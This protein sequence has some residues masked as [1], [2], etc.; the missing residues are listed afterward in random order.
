[1]KTRQKTPFYIF[2]AGALL[3]SSLIQLAIPSYAK[4]MVPLAAE[5][6]A[7]A[8]ATTVLAARTT[9]IAAKPAQ[10]AAATSVA[11]SATA[12]IDLVDPMI[13]TGGHGHTYPGASLPFGLVQLSP[14]TRVTTWDGCS[15]YH[16]SD[17]SIMGFSHTHL[18]GTGCGDLGDIL[19]LPTTE[20][21]HIANADDAKKYHAAFEHSDE[22]ASPG[23]YSVMLKP[24]GIKAE[25]TATKRVGFHRYTFPKTKTATIVVDLVHGIQDEPIEETI[26]IV[27][28]N[29]V[30][31]MRRSKGWAKDEYVYFAAKFSKPF[32]AYDP[33]Q[34]ENGAPAPLTEKQGKAVRAALRFDTTDGAPL[35]AKVGL[36]YADVDGALK[37]LETEAKDLDFDQAHKQAREAWQSE[38][39]K[40]DLKCAN[41]ELAKTFY[42]ALYHSLLA[43]V[44]I[45]DV[46]GRYRGSDIAV[47]TAKDFENYSTFSLWDT[48]RAE[49]PLFTIIEPARVTDMLKSF[50]VQAQ[51]QEKKLLPIWP[52]DSNE[53]FCMIG[54]HSFPVIAEAYLKG[55]RGYDVNKLYQLM[56]ENSKAN[57]WWYEKGYLPADK[58]ME[59]VSKTLEFAYDD[60]CLAQL[61]KALGHSDDEK[62][63]SQR[64]QV[65]KNLFDKQ[66]NIMRGKL[67]DGSWRTPFDPI[68]VRRPDQPW[69][70]TE[71]NAWQY[72]F[73]VLQDIPGMIELYGGREKFVAKLDEMFTTKLPDAVGLTDITG[74]I[75]QYAQ[76][77]EP[78]HHIAYLYTCAGAPNKAAERIK[79]IR[80]RYYT[81]APDGLCGNEDCGQMSAWYVFSALGFYPVN[82]VSAQYIFGTPAFEEATITLP[83]GKKFSVLAH[84]VSSEKFYI[85]KALL[86]GKVLDRNYVTHDEIMNGGT[87]E[88]VMAARLTPVRNGI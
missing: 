72:A 51:Y 35:V 26:K 44:I 32:F 87:L 5:D 2:G 1:M 60:Y 57:D 67:A 59:S 39:Q 17:H 83:N 37:N 18:S 36:S 74:V 69:D 43:P 33:A 82:P 63:Y 41:K 22:S 7:V 71:G 78:S 42:T 24:S 21:V 31:G 30:T 58:E 20:N 19:F 6:K 34:A 40:L 3:L 85:E 25:L 70:F 29:T 9:Q 56:V 27:D 76:G 38:L 65:Y 48:F 46:D 15:G 45:S 86:N 8:S 23:Y 84:G 12:Q 11:G 80:D 49:N 66:T 54:Y 64:G 13:G 53:T 10:M 62:K 16:Y 68:W 50:E 79:E 4:E 47:H 28:A 88:F 81:S 77:N 55:I 14:D 75:G 61:A 73:F 52:L